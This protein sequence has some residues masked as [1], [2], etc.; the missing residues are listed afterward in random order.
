M[1]IAEQIRHRYGNKAVFVTGGA[2]GCVI[3][4]QGVAEQIPAFKVKQ[5]DSTGAGDAFLGGVLAGIRWGLPWA[6]IGRL[7]NAAGAVCV[8][9]V[10]AFPSSF[11]LRGEVAKFYGDRL[12]DPTWDAGEDSAAGCLEPQNLRPDARSLAPARPHK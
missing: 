6:A 10:G 5:I 11:E 3:A 2:E 8:T 7:G 9:R 12:P 1:Q 4:A